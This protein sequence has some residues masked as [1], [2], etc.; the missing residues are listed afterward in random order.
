MIPVETTPGMGD[1][2]EGGMKEKCWGGVNSCM[3]Y[4]TL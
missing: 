2:R 4:D 3:I 1:E